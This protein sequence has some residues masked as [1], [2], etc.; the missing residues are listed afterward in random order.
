MEGRLQEARSHFDR[1]V[2]LGYPVDPETAADWSTLGV[3]E[4]A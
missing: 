2:S 3:E 4:P 1:A